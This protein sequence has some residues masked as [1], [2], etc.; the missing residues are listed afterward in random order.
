LLTDQLH[1]DELSRLVDHGRVAIRATGLRME[2]LILGGD[3]DLDL[4]AV[5]P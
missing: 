5:A 2:S 4:G 3:P 1:D